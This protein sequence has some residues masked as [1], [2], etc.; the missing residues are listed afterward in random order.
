MAPSPVLFGPSGRSYSGTSLLI[1]RVPAHQVCTER[2]LN[3]SLD[4]T[5]KPHPL[6]LLPPCNAWRSDKQG[7]DVRE[8]GHMQSVV[9]SQ[10]HPQMSGLA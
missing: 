9:L 8:L 4:P 2:G 1:S 6:N 5:V 3:L 10:R 7:R